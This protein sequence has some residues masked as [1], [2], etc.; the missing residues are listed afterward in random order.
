MDHRVRSELSIGDQI[1]ASGCDLARSTPRREGGNTFIGPDVHEALEARAKH[2][3]AE[4]LARRQGQRLIF[5]RDLLETLRKCE[6]DAAGAKLATETGLPRH[7]LAEGESVSRI[8]RQRIPPPRKGASAGGWRK[9]QGMLCFKPQKR[10]M[11]V[12]M[13][14]PRA[15]VCARRR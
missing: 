9:D 11:H 2:L 6:L 12:A 7:T 1:H 13:K 5:A 4:G 10:S 3:I 14:T 15:L 8:Y